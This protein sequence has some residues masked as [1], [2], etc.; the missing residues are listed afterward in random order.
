MS[1]KELFSLVRKGKNDSAS[2]SLCPTSSLQWHAPQAHEAAGIAPAFLLPIPTHPAEIQPPP[3]SHKTL[4]AWHRDIHMGI[5]LIQDQPRWC[6]KKWFILSLSGIFMAI[7][8]HCRLPV[9]F[10]ILSVPLGWAQCA[11]RSSKMQHHF[12]LHWATPG[13][14]PVRGDRTQLSAGDL[15]LCLHVSSSTPQ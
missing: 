1:G 2:T 11:A 9:H 3:H 4:W 10:V 5:F 14:P 13:L 6:L 12:R 8:C 7:N 15:G